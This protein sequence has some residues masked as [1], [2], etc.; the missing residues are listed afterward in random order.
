MRFEKGCV[1]DAV[2]T[3]YFFA[4]IAEIFFPR[5]DAVRGL[6]CILGGYIQGAGIDQRVIWYP[7][8]LGNA[9][10]LALAKLLPTMPTLEYPISPLVAERFIDL[11]LDLKGRPSWLPRFLEDHHVRRAAVNR[12]IFFN[13]IKSKFEAGLKSKEF[14]AFNSSMSSISELKGAAYINLKSLEDFSMKIGYRVPVS[15]NELPEAVEIEL[16]DDADVRFE[17]KAPLGFGS[18][19]MRYGLRRP[20]PFSGLSYTGL[21]DVEPGVLTTSGVF[22]RKIPGEIFSRWSVEVAADNNIHENEES[23]AQLRL[24]AF[25]DNSK[26]WGSP[27]A[28]ILEYKIASRGNPAELRAQENHIQ[29][30]SEILEESSPLKTNLLDAELKSSAS[31]EQHPQSEFETISK[32]ANSKNSDVG[33]EPSMNT[34]KSDKRILRLSQLEVKISMSKAS[35]YN[36]MKEGHSQ[37][38]DDFPKSISIGANSVGWIEDEIDVWIGKRSKRK[39]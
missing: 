39:G 7:V 10:W 18:D 16:L 8:E 13:E 4:L 20:G 36:M 35:I 23:L 15:S 25:H 17:N 3:D 19:L 30:D 24:R 37:Y 32:A 22:T 27:A 2:G 33:I 26:L 29:D 38:D 31:R 5:L 14:F 1:K 12:K 6:D 34:S 28:D 21:Y 11:F 9:E